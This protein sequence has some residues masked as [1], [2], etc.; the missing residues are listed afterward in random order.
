MNDV[1]IQER[2]KHTKLEKEGNNDIWK[3]WLTIRT[4]DN[5]QTRFLALALAY[6]VLQLQMRQCDGICF[7]L[8][9]IICM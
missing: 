8:L 1:T 7:K 6:A 5:V 4:S 9:K 2:N 3:I